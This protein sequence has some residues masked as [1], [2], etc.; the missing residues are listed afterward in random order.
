MDRK[1]IALLFLTGIL[2]VPLFMACTKEMEDQAAN[3]FIDKLLGSSPTPTEERIDLNLTINLVIFDWLE[4]LNKSR[5][6]PVAN[7]KIQLTT[8]R[9]HDNETGFDLKEMEMTT[10]KEG[11]VTFKVLFSRVYPKDVIDYEYDRHIISPQKGGPATWEIYKITRRSLD[12]K[13]IKSLTYD[14]KNKSFS[15]V[16]SDEG[17][18]TTIGR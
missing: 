7:K 10:G 14:Q 9:F 15:L 3:A 1:K 17:Y 12:Y 16:V 11:D 5:K 8:S 4:Y 6:V 18:Y 2:I 13:A